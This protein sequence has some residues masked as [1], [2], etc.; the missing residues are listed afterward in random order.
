MIPPLLEEPRTKRTTINTAIRATTPSL[1]ETAKEMMT[2]GVAAAMTPQV[3]ENFMPV[4]VRVAG[5]EA[6]CPPCLRSLA[7]LRRDGQLAGRVF[8]IRNLEHTQR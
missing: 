3:L 6:S 7:T 2:S 8:S 5:S 1:T 4:T